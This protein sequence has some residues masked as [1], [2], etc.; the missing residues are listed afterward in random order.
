VSGEPAGIRAIGL[1]KSYDS[2]QAVRGIDLEIA[3]G[4]T[5]A[6]LGPNGAGKT[7]TID[8]I[9]GLRSPDA[10]T[11]TVCGLFPASAVRMGLVGG[12]LQTG[13]LPD[14]L[15]VRELVSLVASYYP[16]PLPVDEVL[17]ITGLG[18]L[19]ARRTT[20]L[21]GGQAQLVRFAA[22]LVAN[23][24]LLVLDEPT[25]GIDVE[26]RREFWQV[27]RGLAAKGKTIVFA[28]HYLE[29]ADAFAD[30]IVLIAQGR[31]VADG[32]ATEIKAKVGSRSVRATLP[33]VDLAL[34]RTLPG[35]TNVERHGDTV[36]L[37]C[38]DADAALP[39]LFA[40]FPEARDVEAAGGSLE[41]AFLELTADGGHPLPEEVAE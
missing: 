25:A 1:T 28:T 21:S 32:P 7:T 19:A 15:R 34:L 27:M 3:S 17:T 13:S 11:V 5:V 2:V 12:M 33:G 41:E 10:G 23:S 35:V 6:L 40:R 39:A 26:G 16:H 4:E 18:D 38:S 8:M 37:S 22:A 36:I 30:R 31:I 29:E 24:D 9:L 14:F 20:N